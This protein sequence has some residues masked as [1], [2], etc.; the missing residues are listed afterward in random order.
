MDMVRERSLGLEA[1][2]RWQHPELGLVPPD[3]F[4]KL[5]RTA[6]DHV[7]RRMGAPDGL[8]A[9]A[10]MAGRGASR[11]AGGSECVRVQFRH[12]GFRDLIRRV[13]HET[14]LLPDTS[15]WNSPKASCYRM[16][17]SPSRFCRR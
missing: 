6:S 13:L 1:L 8:L 9:G 5:L 11:S 16:Q 10:K 14:G 17:M 7:H 4:S 2:L 15:N 12:D 3:K